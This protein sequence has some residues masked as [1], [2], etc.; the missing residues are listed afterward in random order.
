MTINCDKRAKITNLLPTATNLLSSTFTCNTYNSARKSQK[1]QKFLHKWW[2]SCCRTAL[3]LQQVLYKHP[4]T[5]EYNQNTTS[6]VLNCKKKRCSCTHQRIRT[7][8]DCRVLEVWVYIN[9]QFS[10]RVIAVNPSKMVVV[11]GP[12]VSYQK[13]F[14]ATLLYRDS[15][16]SR[17]CLLLID[18]K[19]IMA[20]KY[21]FVNLLCISGRGFLPPLAGY[22]CWF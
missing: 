7:Q 14:S 1:I 12:V 19:E 22:I 8:I 6:W 10:L 18:L 13:T 20:T 3:Y 21:H 17:Q 15:A 5:Y 4:F 9:F 11:W 16:V 2:F